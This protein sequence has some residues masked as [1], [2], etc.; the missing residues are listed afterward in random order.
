MT[1]GELLD[2]KQNRELRDKFAM[3]A[4]NGLLSEQAGQC[5]VDAEVAYKYADAMME[6]RK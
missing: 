6:A 3:A 4:L 1:P 5:K 2:V